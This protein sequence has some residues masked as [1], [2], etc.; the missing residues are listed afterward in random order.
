MVLLSAFERAE[1]YI[2]RARSAV[3]WANEQYRGFLEMMERTGS[4]IIP[5]QQEVA[6]E[7]MALRGRLFGKGPF[8]RLREDPN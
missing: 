6:S 2:L 3:S 1:T 8:A 5:Q 4:G 7:N